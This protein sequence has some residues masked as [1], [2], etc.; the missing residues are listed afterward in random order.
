MGFPSAYR[1]ERA[2]WFWMCSQGLPRVSAM[3]P[4]LQTHPSIRVPS[5]L[6]AELAAIPVSIAR[7]Q[8][9]R[10]ATPDGLL[11]LEQGIRQELHELMQDISAFLAPREGTIVAEWLDGILYSMQQ[12]WPLLQQEVMEERRAEHNLVLREFHAQAQHNVVERR[13]PNTRRHGRRPC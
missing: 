11:D 7:L 12:C 1:G 13:D 8:R 9:N 4:C 10:H 5:D 6:A 2:Q 3:P